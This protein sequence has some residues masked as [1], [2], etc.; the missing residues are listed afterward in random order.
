[1]NALMSLV[2]RPSHAVPGPCIANVADVVELVSTEHYRQAYGGEEPDEYAA[3]AYA[4]VQVIVDALR[5]VAADRPSAEA[6]ARPCGPMSSI[7]RTAIT[8]SSETLPSTSMATRSASAS[9]SI[10]STLGRG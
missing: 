4:C 5:A 2:L 3:A 8:R 10:G 9:L 1:M 6:C 7:R